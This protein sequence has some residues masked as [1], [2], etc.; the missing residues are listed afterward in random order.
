M[1][2][3]SSF[4]SVSF[5]AKA[6]I[7]SLLILVCA[8]VAHCQDTTYH[9]ASYTAHFRKSLKQPTFVTYTLYKA[10]GECSRAGDRF[11]GTYLTVKQSD[12][13]HSGYDEGHL[14]DSKDFAYDCQA[15][16][17]TFR[18]YNCV[19]QTPNLNRG[20]WKTWETK[21]RAESQAD[22]L[23]VICGGVDFVK[24]KSL[25]VPT[26]C[27]KIV[28]NLHTQIVTHVLYCTNNS[29]AT[30]DEVDIAVVYDRLDPEIATEIEKEIK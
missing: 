24:V 23:L 2:L 3:S 26:Y 18:F 1:T 17:S 8:S 9:E 10:G 15:Q 22:S 13:D 4:K 16:E 7:V 21:I 30:C 11:K 29:N 12:Y 19:P 6:V 25:Y 27:F 28:E 20:I 5:L 14:A